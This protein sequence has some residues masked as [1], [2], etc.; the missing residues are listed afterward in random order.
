MAKAICTGNNDSKILTGKVTNI[1][2]YNH[3]NGWA[4]FRIDIKENKEIKGIGKSI[5]CSGTIPEI[6]R[7]DVLTL[8]GYI[9]E[10]KK[11]GKQFKVLRFT[12]DSIVTSEST[13]EQIQAYLC[14]GCIKGIGPARGEKIFSMFGSEAFDI[15]ENDFMRLTEVDGIGKATA[16]KIHN[17]YSVD[18]SVRSIVSALL[19]FGMSPTLAYKLYK[20][21]GINAVEVVKMNP[22]LM[23]DPE[24]GVDGVGFKTADS[25]AMKMGIDIHSPLRLQ[26]LIVYLLMH[27]SMDGNI[28]YTYEELLKVGDEYFTGISPEEIRENLDILCEANKVIIEENRIYAISYYLMEQ[29]NAQKLVSLHQSILKDC[30]LDFKKIE[31]KLGN[32]KYDEGQKLAIETAS[33]DTTGVMVLT[34][35]PGCDSFLT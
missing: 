25:I 6:Q 23:A 35:G 12:D 18:S 30:A 3:E 7:G 1:Y 34:G 15:I 8:Q 13:P 29:F 22:Y 9:E 2:Y 28:F 20:K 31:E 19:P 21:W 26:S 14:S 10:T 32:I 24:D 17:N 4:S 33:L 27:G 11:Y 5:N 16:E